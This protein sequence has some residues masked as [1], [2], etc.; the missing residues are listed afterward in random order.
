M[1]IEFITDSTWTI[2]IVPLFI[3]LVVF[4][5]VAVVVSEYRRHSGNFSIASVVW[6]IGSVMAPM[7]VPLIY[8][9]VRLAS[10]KEAAVLA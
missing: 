4:S 8:L 9:V 1:K 5:V 3:A 7:L 10:R 6:I 2:L